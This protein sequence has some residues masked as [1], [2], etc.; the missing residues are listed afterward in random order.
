[1]TLHY[2]E[3]ND[4]ARILSE[5]KYVGDLIF[6]KTVTP[7]YLDHIQVKN[8][9]IEEKIYHTDRHEPI[10]DRVTWNMAREIQEKRVTKADTGSRHSK[11]Y[12][13][14]GKLRC[15]EC[16]SYVISR[17]K[18]N[19]DGTV[20]RFWYCREGY[21]FGKHRKSN[22]GVELGCNS[23]LIGDRALIECVRFA[24]GHL[25]VACNIRQAS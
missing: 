12:W 14:S 24:V 1:M 20:I 22:S 23:N 9:G 11:R 19:K 4:V 2:A 18:Y 7:N 3:L 15:A 8:D 16:G 17:N 25:K 13:C 10:I 21:I 5:E 6:K